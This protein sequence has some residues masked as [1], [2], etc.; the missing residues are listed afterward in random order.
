MPEAS[1]VKISELLPKSLDGMGAKVAEQLRNA[2]QK[3]MTG[4]AWGFV[5]EKA[6]EQ[7]RLALDLDVFEVLARGW[8]FA[9]EL[10]KYKDPEQYPPDKII[11]VHLGEHD[12]P[13]LSMYPEVQVMFGPIPGPKLRFTLEFTVHI[14][15]IALGIRGAH[16]TSVS[17][18][19]GSVAVQIKYGDVDLHP[20]LES[21]PVSLSETLTFPGSGLALA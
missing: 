7:L 5:G 3:S 9:K 16:I 4:V 10:R 11:T 13:S 12:L 21:Q 18:G 20:A 1:G 14:R 17:A 15:S 8:C 6:V 2:P 19:D